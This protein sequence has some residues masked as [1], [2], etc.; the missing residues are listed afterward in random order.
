MKHGQRVAVAGASGFVGQNLVSALLQHGAHVLALCRNPGAVDWPTASAGELTV[1][2]VDVA[3]TERLTDE[4]QTFGADSA[5]YLIHSMG[6]GI[7]ERDAFVE[8]DRRL[9]RSFATAAAQA[10]IGQVIYLGG[11]TPAGDFISD[12]LE[13]RADVARSFRRSGLMVTELRAG[14]VIDLQSAAFRMLSTIIERQSVLLI[15]PQ[16]KNLGHP[17]AVDDAVACLLAALD[18]PESCRNRTYDIGCKDACRYVDLIGWYAKLLGQA[19]RMVDIPWA[20]REMI[21]PYV[22][23]ITG[24]DFG[25]VWALSGSWGVDLPIRESGLYDR[26]P[27][28]PRTSAEEAV[29]QALDSGR[30]TQIQPSR[31]AR[32]AS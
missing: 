30:R 13:S 15:P 25:L 8:L 14:V 27:N 22:A 2:A 6:G 20:P 10:A 1:L 11:H 5:Y 24:E 3:N 18:L 28:L 19:P 16:F 29:R 7:E 12:H 17:I 32:E 21:V 9:A 4:L 26:F 31:S 23:A